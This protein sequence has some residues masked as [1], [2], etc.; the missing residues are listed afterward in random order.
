MFSLSTQAA[1]SGG[2][3]Y[4][5]ENVGY[6]P[7]TGLENIRNFPIDRM[8]KLS[9]TWNTNPYIQSLGSAHRRPPKW[10]QGASD[11]KWP[12]EASAARPSKWPQVT[13]S[14]S[15]WPQ[16]T[17]S[18]RFSKIQF[19][20][21]LHALW[22]FRTHDHNNFILWSHLLQKI[23]IEL[24]CRVSNKTRV[25]LLVVLRVY[26]QVFDG[27][28][29]HLNEKPSMIWVIFGASLV[30]RFPF[31]TMDRQV[32]FSNRWTCSSDHRLLEGGGNF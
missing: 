3:N 22:S 21:H 28:F 24:A 23:V 8:P 26:F 14:D 1:L 31:D 30:C 11:R 19:L 12:P 17:A 13:A 2:K 9:P 18:D 29:L 10:L 6:F 20:L 32:R 16:V 25:T 5:L 15:K 27:G 4:G 7:S